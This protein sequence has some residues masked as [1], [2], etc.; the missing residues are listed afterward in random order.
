MVFFSICCTSALLG[1]AHLL[2]VVD[3]KELEPLSVLERPLLREPHE[4]TDAR[5]GEQQAHEDEQNQDLHSALQRDSRR[6][7]TVAPST[8]SE[9]AGMRIAASQGAMSPAV[10]R[11][12]ASVL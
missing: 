7:A 11:P 10:A 12:M 3:G 4:E 5:A 6:D 8:T 9:L 1:R 2:R